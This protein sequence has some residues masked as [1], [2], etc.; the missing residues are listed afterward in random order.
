[1]DG[2]GESN[3]VAKFVL[4]GQARLEVVDRE[5]DRA[6]FTPKLRLDGELQ[7]TVRRLMSHKHIPMHLR[8]IIIHKSGL[9]D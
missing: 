4:L 7:W 9:V 8:H 5:L 3:I 6:P 1:M 2:F